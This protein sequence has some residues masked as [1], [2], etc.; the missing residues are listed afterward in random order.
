MRVLEAFA[1]DVHI[2][3]IGRIVVGFRARLP[4]ILIPSRS[5]HVMNS[6]MVTAGGFRCH[7][8]E[9]SGLECCKRLRNRGMLSAED[10]NTRE[11]QFAQRPHADSGN[12]N[13]VQRFTPERCKRSA[14]AVVMVLIEVRDGTTQLAVSVHYQKTRRRAEV[15]AHSAFNTLVFIY[16]NTEIH[17]NSFLYELDQLPPP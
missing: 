9:L 6:P 14:H 7:R 2:I 15:I 1:N 3:P 5:G 13:P 10:S 17:D 8:L 11:L 4:V 16:W 12:D